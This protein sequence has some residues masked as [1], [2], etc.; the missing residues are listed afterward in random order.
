M[1]SKT[2]SRY[3]DS[4]VST[5]EPTT[6][7]DEQATSERTC[8][9]CDGRL[10]SDGHETVCEDCGLVAKTD[11]IEQGP[12]IGVHGP[13]TGSGPKEW[14][15]ESVNQLRIDKGLHTTFFLGSDGKGRSLSSEQKDKFGRLRRRHKRFQVQ[16]KRAIRLNEGYRDIEMI[17]GNLGL[18]QHVLGTAGQYM[19]QAAAERLPGGRMSWE[20]LAAGSVLL[21]A[22]AEGYPRTPSEV[23]QYAKSSGERVRAAARKVRCGLGLD[24]PPVDDDLV[25]LVLI[26]LEDQL[27]VQTCLELRAVSEH[28]VELADAEAIGEGTTRLTVA[29]SAVY[30]ADRVT[31]GKTVTQAAVVEAASTIVDT[32]KSRVSRYSRLLYDAYVAKHGSDDPG[33]VLGRAQGRLG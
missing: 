18:P 28:L 32:T 23:S 16:S 20:A 9:E 25:E 8:E 5:T 31:D 14:S 15:C 17:G 3:E 6:A 19:Q 10:I 33:A 2:L 22:R 21:A 30:A 7:T 11:Y 1:S 13:S 24:V 27:D 29:A 4:G 12:T 26:A